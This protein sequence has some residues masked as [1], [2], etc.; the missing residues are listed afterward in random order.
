MAPQSLAG[1]RLIAFEGLDGV[2]KTTQARLLADNLARRGLPV[3]LTREPTDGVWGQ[4]IRQISQRGRSGMAPA[5][6]LALFLADRREH[7]EKVIRP[8]LAAGQIVITDRYYYSSMAYQGALGLDP[9]AIAAQHFVFAPPPD[10]IILLEVPPA[11]R[12]KRLRQR[13]TKS[14]MFEEQDYQ[15]KVAAIFDRLQA[16]NLIRVDG[17]GSVAAVQARI[18]AQVQQRLRLPESSLPVD[19]NT[20]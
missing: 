6:E 12:G 11:E 18:L 20:P 4:K 16:P 17:R 5:E 13:G 10:L 14:D 15:A 2:G 9:E 3:V 1:G 7:V 8:A 19:G